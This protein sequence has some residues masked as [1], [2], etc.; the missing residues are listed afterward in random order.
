MPA[1]LSLSR[2]AKNSSGVFGSAAMPALANAAFEY[3]NH[4]GMWMSTGTA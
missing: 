3:Q 4:A 2:S 1:A